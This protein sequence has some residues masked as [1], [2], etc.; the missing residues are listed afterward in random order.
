[1]LRPLGERVIIKRFEAEEKTASGIVIPSQAKEKPL[2]A[3][4]VAV[5][6]EVKDLKKGD[7]VLFKKYSGNEV[8]VDEEDLIVIAAEDILAVFE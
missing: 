2:M 6:N 7:K 4:V 5:S 8:K 1:M 3:E